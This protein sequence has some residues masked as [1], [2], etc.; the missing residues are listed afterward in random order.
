MTLNQA[1]NAIESH[2]TAYLQKPEVVI[3]VLA[4][5][6]KVYYVVY[7]LGGAGQRIYRLPST[8]NETVLDAVSQL[9]GLSPVSDQ[10]RIWIARSS[11]DSEEEK[12]CLLIGT[13]LLLAVRAI[14]TTSCCPAIVYL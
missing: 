11:K 2:L 5:N 13:T 14:P 8:G 9:T 7:D 6:S 3:D 4:Y 12:S 10:D 1:K